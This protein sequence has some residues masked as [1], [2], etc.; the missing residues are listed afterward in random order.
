MSKR[1]LKRDRADVLRDR[2]RLLAVRTSVET[3]AAYV[4]DA[5][6]D[7]SSS[8]VRMVEDLSALHGLVEMDL[9]HNHDRLV[10]IDAELAGSKRAVR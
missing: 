5:I 3:L 6:S 8:K 10:A 1:A 4:E 7:K 9:A 2:T